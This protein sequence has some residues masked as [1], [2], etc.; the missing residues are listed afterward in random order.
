MRTCKSTLR[1]LTRFLNVTTRHQQFL[2]FSKPYILGKFSLTIH[3]LALDLWI[4]HNHFFNMDKQK[5][6]QHYQKTLLGKLRCNLLH[7]ISG[8]NSIPDKEVVKEF[9][10]KKLNSNTC[11]WRMYS[12]ILL[13]PSFDWKSYSSLKEPE[14]ISTLLE[15]IEK[16]PLRNNY[17]DQEEE[18]L[19]DQVFIELEGCPHPFPETIG[20]LAQM[21]ELENVD[22]GFVYD[23]YL[24]EQDK[25]PDQAIDYIQVRAC[26]SQPD[27]I[28]CTIQI[29]DG[30]TSDL[31]LIVALPTVRIAL[32]VLSYLSDSIM[33]K[34]RENQRREKEKKI[35]NTTNL[36]PVS[37]NIGARF[38]KQG[39]GNI[40]FAIVIGDEASAEEL[41]SSWLQIDALRTRLREH[42]GTN[43][44][45]LKHSLLYNYYQM[46]KHGWSYSLI[47]MDINYDCLVNLCRANDEIV[48]IDAKR[49]ESI[50]L[51]HA[52]S[53][54]QSVRMKE[55]DILDWLIPGLKELRSGNCPW[56]LQRGPV[57][58]QR[59]RDSIR[60]WKNE[61]L[62][63]KI[64][65]KAPPQVRKASIKSLTENPS[66]NRYNQIAKDLL[67]D[68]YPD[69]YEKYDRAIS[70]IIKTTG[71]LGYAHPS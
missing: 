70:K 16:F 8:C 20:I 27:P 50:S 31:D 2:L 53:L 35:I 15:Q 29:D 49:I 30:K 1:F 33:L 46:H 4:K 71:Y 43:L 24:L 69:D 21:Y 23:I 61:E 65:V 13:L 7:K 52:I 64:I 32:Q 45:Q 60:P 51:T 12:S 48:D 38:L 59:V 37:E 5:L 41:R 54:L 57:D 28:I 56:S 55:K 67:E 62:S 26:K 36:M 6:V 11:M 17:I 9:M 42:Q 66:Y 3:S 58:K 40:E 68:T 39:S 18:G 22:H 44:N 14:D 19:K 34:E 47:A 10:L 25:F 63:P